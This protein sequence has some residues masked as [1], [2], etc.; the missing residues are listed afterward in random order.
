MILVYIHGANSSS[1]SWNYIRQ[2]LDYKGQELLLDYDSDNG[3]D[4]NLKNMI[5]H[6]SHTD[7]HQPLYFVAHSL[8]GVYALH[9]AQEFKNR[10]KGGFTISTPYGGCESASLLHIMF[11]R[12]QLLNDIAPHSWPM[13]RISQ[14]TIP[15][16]WTTVITTGGD[17]PLFLGQAN[18][19]V[20]TVKSQQALQAKNQVNL[21]FN[22]Y[23]ILQSTKLTSILTK[24]LANI[25]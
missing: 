21:E 8:G 18:D 12:E 20:V 11:P 5:T 1:A 19:G 7:E 23:E 15:N 17:N 10:T 14:F 22:H 16:N 4:S 6:L 2:Q 3:F 24:R 25:F 13:R 9:L